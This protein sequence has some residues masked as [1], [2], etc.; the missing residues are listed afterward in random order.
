L[1][2]RP[3]ML[4]YKYTAYF[5]VSS[6]GPSAEKVSHHRVHRYN[7]NPR[8]KKIYINGESAGRNES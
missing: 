2:E 3:S 8:R 1:R 7:Y 6:F 4:R 5:V